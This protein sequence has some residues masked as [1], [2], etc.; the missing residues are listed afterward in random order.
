MHFSPL[1]KTDEIYPLENF[2]RDIRQLAKYCDI[3]TFRLIG[4]EP[5]LLKNLGEYVKV[6]RQYLPNTDLRIATNGL[7]I[8]S[9]PQKLL[10]TI[11]ENNFKFDV[12]LYPPTVKI[13][14]KI[15]AVCTA[16]KIMCNLVRVD[17]EGNFTVIMSL[18]GNNDP[19]KSQASCINDNCRF[20]R[21]GKLYKCPLDALSYRFAEKFGLENFPA[22]SGVDLY[23]QN[24]SAMLAQLD[25]NPVEL[26]HW[27][28]ERVRKIP[29]DLAGKPKL[30]DWLADPDELKNF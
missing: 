1:F 28:S 26:C 7:L 14:D 4:G 27:C 10:D 22:S 21:D 12:T 5:L 18:R 6:T 19:I 8:P 9:L 23:A 3:L 30:E 24:V 16:N 13:C 15:K 29:W 17:S 2:R 20:M 11:R 25:N